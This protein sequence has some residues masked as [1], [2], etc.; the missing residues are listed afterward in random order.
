MNRRGR[1]EASPFCS[2]DDIDSCPLRHVTFYDRYR[3]VNDFSR[4]D[5]T[6]RIHPRF[7]SPPSPER[8]DGPPTAVLSTAEIIYF[9][10]FFFSFPSKTINHTPAS[11]SRVHL[12]NFHTLD[13]LVNTRGKNPKAIIKLVM[14]RDNNSKEG[15]KERIKE[16]LFSLFVTKREKGSETNPP[17]NSNFLSIYT[18]FVLQSNELLPLPEWK[19]AKSGSLRGG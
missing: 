5:D 15:N 17:K 3:A 2:M 18:F 13:P 10:L 4:R 6:S 11:S 8:N 16:W 7:V 9:F 19:G 1:G 14:E 12:P